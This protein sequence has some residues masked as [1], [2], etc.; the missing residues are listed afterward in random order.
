MIPAG[1]IRD[2]GKLILRLSRAIMCSVFSA[3]VDVIEQL[4]GKQQLGILRSDPYNQE[5]GNLIL[6]DGEKLELLRA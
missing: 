3:G 1:Y 4:A 2:C 5:L 6:E